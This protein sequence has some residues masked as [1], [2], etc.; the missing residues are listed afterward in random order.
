MIARRH[1]PAVKKH[2]NRKVLAHIHYR[3]F[4]FFLSTFSHS[5]EQVV[6]YFKCRANYGFGYLQFLLAKKTNVYLCHKFLNIR[7]QYFNHR[8]SWHTCNHLIHWVPRCILHFGQLTVCIVFTIGCQIL[9]Q[10]FRNVALFR[11]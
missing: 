1:C 9:V 5:K 7:L 11:T 10:I 4:F 3:L 8:T 6:N 2:L